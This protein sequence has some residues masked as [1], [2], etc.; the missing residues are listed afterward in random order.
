MITHHQTSTIRF[1]LL[2]LCLLYLP[3][4]QSRTQ[5]AKTLIADASS[6]LEQD[7]KV[8]TAW[9]AEYSKMF[10]PENRARFP[11][12]RESL[13]SQGEKV[14]KLLDESAKLSVR[15]A[16]KFEQ[17]AAL[18][19]E[20]RA[21]QGMALFASA[22][23]KE[24]EIADLFKQQLRL[25]SDHEIKDQK[26]FDEKFLNLMQIIQKKRTEKDKQQDEAKKL[27]GL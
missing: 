5:Q 3:G 25:A 4:C 26:A 2:V 8:T 27:L 11:A 7:T 6:L 23:R 20:R 22:L 1:V 21:K 17:A 9:T 13:R 16:E 15:G 24:V 12:N 18:V 10:T 19:S 14:T